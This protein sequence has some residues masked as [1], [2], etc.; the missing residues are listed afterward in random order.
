VTKLIL[1]V[2]DEEDVRDALAGILSSYGYSTVTAGNAEDALRI[3]ATLEVDAL[4]TDVVMPGRMS[5]FDLARRARELNPHLPILCIT[6]YT[7]I[8]DVDDACEAVLR[9][10]CPPIQLEKEF[11]ALFEE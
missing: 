2:D 11:E 5:G 1:V 8:P 7:D 6:G 4:F 3:L 9:K 10:P